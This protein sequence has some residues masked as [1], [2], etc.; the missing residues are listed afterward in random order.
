M[1]LDDLLLVW[2]PQLLARIL[3]L[4][5]PLLKWSLLEIRRHILLIWICMLLKVLG[6]NQMLGLKRRLLLLGTKLLRM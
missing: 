6:R 4:L 5:L 1:E 3:L 2:M